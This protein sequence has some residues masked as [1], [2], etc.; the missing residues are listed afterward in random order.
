MIF[1]NYGSFMKDN[2]YVKTMSKRNNQFEVL[3]RDSWH[4]YYDCK[5]KYKVSC[6]CNEYTSSKSILCEMTQLI[7]LCMKRKLFSLMIY[8]QVYS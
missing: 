4:I 1:A 5:Y 8:I 3:L 6:L 7:Y 2:Y